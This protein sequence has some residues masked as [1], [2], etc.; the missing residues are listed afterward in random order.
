MRL[1]VIL[2]GIN[3]MVEGYS[4]H[5]EKPPVET[6]F[7]KFFVE[8]KTSRYW[9]IILS[10]FLPLRRTCYKGKTV[11]IPDSRRGE[12]SI[13]INLSE[14]WL[15]SE[16]IRTKAIEKSV[17]VRRSNLIINEHGQGQQ[18]TQH[19]LILLYPSHFGVIFRLPSKRPDGVHL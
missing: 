3:I 9:M 13:S 1:F 19:R 8:W 18:M 6:S 10:A 16:R 14:K 17:F 11:V 15:E 2:Q 7:L 4:Q 12:R 5:I